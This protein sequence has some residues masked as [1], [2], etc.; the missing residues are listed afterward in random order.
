MTVVVAILIPF[1]ILSQKKLIG[2]TFQ[3]ELV[4][5]RCKIN[6]SHTHTH[7]FW[8]LETLQCHS[9]GENFDT[10]RGGRRVGANKELTPDNPLAPASGLALSERDT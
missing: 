2:T 8:H 6:V 9:V 7:G 1:R 4:P 10:V 3:K 5:L